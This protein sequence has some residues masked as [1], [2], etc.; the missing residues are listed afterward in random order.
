MHETRIA[1]AGAPFFFLVLPRGHRMGLLA[2][3]MPWHI[4]YR[5]LEAT[6]NCVLALLQA[7][8]R[9]LA[10][11]IPGSTAIPACFMAMTNGETAPVNLLPGLRSC[12]LFQGTH[13]DTNS[14]LET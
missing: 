6:Y 9:K 8:N 12:E 14:T 13:S 2:G 7:Q 11:A 1:I 3:V 4:P 10:F 5:V